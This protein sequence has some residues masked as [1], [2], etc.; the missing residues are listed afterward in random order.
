MRLSNQKREF[1]RM[2]PTICCHKRL[3]KDINKL[4][5]KGFFKKIF[6]TNSNQKRTEVVILIAEKKLLQEIKN[7]IY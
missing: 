6:H 7:I 1:G 3:T 5:M 2:D 4:K